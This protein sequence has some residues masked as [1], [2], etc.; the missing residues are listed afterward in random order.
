MS[1]NW[2]IIS[3]TYFKLLGITY[4]VDLTMSYDKNYEK[5]YKKNKKKLIVEQ[6]NKRN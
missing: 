4:N 6:W 2:I 5:N 1:G 3:T